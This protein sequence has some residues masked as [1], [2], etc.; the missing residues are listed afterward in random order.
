MD[1]HAI[2]AVP[3]QF[4]QYAKQE[5]SPLFALLPFDIRNEIF[6]YSLTSMPEATRPLSTSPLRVGYCSRPGYETRHR[7]WTELLRTCK[8]TYMEAWHM[9]FACS[10]HAFYLAW[11][12]RCPRH[13][14]SREQMQERLDIIHNRQGDIRAG[15]IRIF[16]QLCLL[17]DSRNLMKFFA[18]R[19]F[20]PKTITVTIRYTDTW[21]WEDNEFL[22][23]SGKW[24]QSIR[25]P[26]SVHKFTIEFES[27][28]RRKDEVDY[29]ARGAADDW[30]F[31]RTDNVSMLANSSQIGLSTWTGCSVLGGRR[32]VR[33]EARPGQL[34]YYIAKVTWR[35]VQ[36]SRANLLDGNPDLAVKWKRRL[37]RNL[38]YDFIVNTELE[39]LGISLDTP[40][41]RAVA[42]YAA[43]TVRERFL[44]VV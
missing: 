26:A 37:P 35:P 14:M 6:A 4:A 25:L 28:E 5:Q 41:E 3:A 44:V 34:D 15:H 8:R 36:E 13:R 33:D 30:Q 20:H 7:I 16:A 39:E 40:A 12:E 32:W 19:H 18:M 21:R 17:E 43:A 42:E 11:E 38:G 23:I 29:I 10:E 1:S 24:C 22:H 31:R 9:P 2:P 27:L